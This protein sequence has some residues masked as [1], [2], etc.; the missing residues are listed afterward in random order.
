MTKPARKVSNADG[1]AAKAHVVEDDAVPIDDS[2]SD[3]KAS[4]LNG[5]TAGRR[6]TEPS[7]KENLASSSQPSLRRSR[8]HAGKGA[9]L[10]QSK[11]GNQ[12]QRAPSAR[13]RKEVAQVSTAAVA[14]AAATTTKKSGSKSTNKKQRTKKCYRPPHLKE[15]IS[16]AL[17]P[18]SRVKDAP[19]PSV[20]NS[21]ND[22]L[23]DFEALAP[24]L[25]EG[26]SPNDVAKQQHVKGLVKRYLPGTLAQLSLSKSDLAASCR[27][28]YELTWDLLMKT[29]GQKLDD[30]QAETLR[31]NLLSLN[32]NETGEKEHFAGFLVTVHN[33]DFLYE[34]LKTAILSIENADRCVSLIAYILGFCAK[35]AKDGSATEAYHSDK[36]TCA[37]KTPF[38]T[39]QSLVMEY[40][41]EETTS[42]RPC[43][44][45]FSCCVRCRSGDNDR[46]LPTTDGEC[47]LA[48]DLILAKRDMT[49]AA[50]KSMGKQLPKQLV[51]SVG[52]KTNNQSVVELLKNSKHRGDLYVAK[53]DNHM[54]AFVSSVYNTSVEKL[55][56]NV[57]EASK[58]ITAAGF[59]RRDG[60]DLY[61]FMAKD[62]KKRAPRLTGESHGANPEHIARAL[63]NV[64]RYGK[65]LPEERA[66]VEVAW[67]LFDAGILPDCD[68]WMPFHVYVALNLLRSPYTVKSRPRFEGP[69]RYYVEKPAQ[70]CP[71]LARQF[72]EAKEALS[73]I[74]GQPQQLIT[75][76]EADQRVRD[77]QKL[78]KAAEQAQEEADQRLREK[79]QSLQTLRE[80]NGNVREEL[81]L[82]KN[83]LEETR[84][85]LEVE[86]QERENALATMRRQL[87]EAAQQQ[88]Q[89]AAAAHESKDGQSQPSLS[90]SV[91]N[92]LTRIHMSQ[93]KP[94]QV[95][96]AVAVARQQLQVAAATAQD[97]AAAQNKI[98]NAERRRGV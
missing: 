81:A 77:E 78:R 73:K 41:D 54:S 6:P 44:V 27:T 66:F 90:K 84:L 61:T 83:E 72:K 37:A 96:R 11:H 95:R 9:A 32:P 74:V 62:P 63:I 53:L 43:N 21:S 49:N 16:I 93:K 5:G 67:K 55:Q 69:A 26:L 31:R 92:T 87:E 57:A 76:D 80:E 18:G 15:G 56:H 33:R 88:Q 25:I 89:Q 98:F 35:D 51:F 48:V 94:Q 58:E 85:E 12:P 38:G 7:G 8:R 64:S 1:P 39:T 42:V 19:R 2:S 4:V 70:L 71:E 28:N 82:K 36:R 20:Y 30:E 59:G 60:T 47:D 50:Y 3:V 17:R 45:R 52:G 65:W 14:A 23:A 22:L 24:R 86:K 34:L 29:A 13:P 75:Q 40:F 46:C 68:H 97:A 79:E 10:S 91:S